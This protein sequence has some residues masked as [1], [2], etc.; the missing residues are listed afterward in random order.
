MMRNTLRAAAIAAAATAACAQAAVYFEEDFQDQTAAKVNVGT[1]DPVWRSSHHNVVVEA[2]E[3][4]Q[5][6]RTSWDTGTQLI[7][8]EFSAVPLSLGQGQPLI[9][10]L[11]YRLTRR[12]T[13]RILIGLQAGEP[14]DPVDHPIAAPPANPTISNFSVFNANPD[15]HYTADWFGYQAQ[16]RLDGHGTDQTLIQRNS[17]P[18]PLEGNVVGSVWFH[19]NQS[20][21]TSPSYLPDVN[22]WRS[23]QLRLSLDAENRV[24]VELWEGPDRDS[25]VLLTSAVDDDPN[26]ILSGYQ[27][28]AIGVTSSG[29]AGGA[30]G[31]PIVHFDNIT[32]VPE[33]AALSLL[34]LAGLMGLRRRRA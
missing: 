31:N 32:V 29:Y 12:D 1:A 34:A 22:I 3:G 19:N 30:A 26:R 24:L 9:L 5:F 8:A 14:W 23:A 7:G 2:Q 10:T 4:N 28:I 13:S 27:H 17:G 20:L 15:T 21:G 33:P 18:A 16:L 6:M 11:D 25:L